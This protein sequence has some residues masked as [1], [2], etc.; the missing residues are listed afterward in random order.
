MTIIPKNI[1]KASVL[2]KLMLFF[3]GC[4]SY[5]DRI[6]LYYK[7]ISDGNYTQAI[8]EL[9]KNKLLQKPRNKLLFL[10]EKGKA[11]HLADDYEN[12][13]RYFNQADQLLENRI[14]GAMDAAVGVLVNP[15]MQS[16]KGEDFEKFMIHYYKALNY[17]YLNLDEDAIVEAR[18]ISLQSIEQ[19]DKF[20]DK[21][22]RYSKDAFSLMLQGLIYE[23]DGDINNA[24]IAYRNAA[25]VYLQNK[26]QTHYGVKIPDEL[27]QDVLRM[28]DKNGFTAELNRFEDLFGLKYQRK[29]EPEG[30]SLIFFWENGRVPIK[31]QEELF[32]SLIKGSNGNLFFTNAGGTILIP[33]DHSYSNSNFSLEGI[34]SLRVT[35][36]KYLAQKPYYNTATLDNGRET[37][38]FEKAEDINELAFKTLEQRFLKEI[39]KVLTRLAVKKSAEYVLQ[40]SAKNKDKDRKDD[41]LL[42]SLGIGMQLY[43]LLSEKADTRNWQSLPAQINYA[44]IP[45]KAGTNIITL[46]LRDAEGAKESKSI[47]IKGMAKKLQFYNHS[48]L[49]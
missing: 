30:G 3:S 48:T 2:L 42:K 41:T 20:N 35:Y 47:E 40:K 36:P 18:R 45:L 6:A 39:G 25:E 13:N 7:Q 9:D 19:S 31:Q 1:F 22:T 26:D 37:V 46:H 32:F 23:R 8:K 49:R 10:M 5:N 29:P 14:G 28:A 43:S 33:F 24:F 11:C 15:M 16:Y 4:A 44:R 34:E 17:I 38:L 27:K 12:S 21:N